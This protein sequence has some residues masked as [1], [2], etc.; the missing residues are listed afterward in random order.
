MYNIK[1]LIFSSTPILPKQTL[2]L[3]LLLYGKITIIT[4]WFLVLIVRD[5]WIYNPRNT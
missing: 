5:E 3:Q 4:L 1:P 2:K